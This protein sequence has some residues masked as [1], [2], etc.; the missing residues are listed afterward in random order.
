MSENVK[1]KDAAGEQLWDEVKKR[2]IA[3]EKL[4]ETIKIALGIYIAG[5]HKQGQVGFILYKPSDLDLEM[6]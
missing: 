2:I 4:D 1:L 3:R 5:S 6:K